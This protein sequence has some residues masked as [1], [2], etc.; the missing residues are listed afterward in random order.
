VS[1]LGGAEGLFDRVEVRHPDGSTEHL[2]RQQ[3][4]AMP[5]SRRVRILIQA[6]L[7]FFR[8]SERVPTREAVRSL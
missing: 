5:I 7:W 4:I 6:D 3:F 2:D 8:G 1:T